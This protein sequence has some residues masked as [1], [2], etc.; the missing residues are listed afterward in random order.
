M[1][2]EPT[3]RPELSQESDEKEGM[4]EGGPAA[5]EI[6]NK[7][8]LLAVLA[9]VKEHAEGYPVELRLASNGRIVIRA[10][11]ECGNNHTD[12]DLH[13]LVAWFREGMPREVFGRVPGRHASLPSTE[14]N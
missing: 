1:A 6:P 8:F 12:V 5:G 13:D 3:D 11:N 9:G 14:R 7:E 10:Y 2:H 4:G